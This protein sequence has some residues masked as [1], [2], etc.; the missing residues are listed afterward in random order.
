MLS[1]IA[2]LE[3]KSKKL[4]GVDPRFANKR[5]TRMVET[6]LV[7]QRNNIPPVGMATDTIAS[8]DAK[9]TSA[10]AGGRRKLNFQK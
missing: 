1:A 7:N 10:S 2:V 9:S 3:R 4:Q 5:M 6:Q 8:V